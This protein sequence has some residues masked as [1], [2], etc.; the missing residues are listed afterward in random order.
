MNFTGNG[1]KKVKFH[2]QGDISNYTADQ[3]EIIKETVAA[4][5]GC[6][7]EEIHL[8][9]FCKSTSFFVVLSIKE[10]CINGLFNMKQQDKEKLTSL[11]IN[12]FIVDSDHV[13]LEHPKG[14][15]YALKTD[16]FMSGISPIYRLSVNLPHST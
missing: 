1:Y 9:G 16:N 13:Y 12:Y 6:K 5:V 15:F 3:I 14:N 2:I 11:N 8:N 7:N 4:A 10:R